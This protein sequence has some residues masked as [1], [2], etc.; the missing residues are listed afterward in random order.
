MGLSTDPAK[1]RRQLEGLA[2]GAE[3]RS[4]TLRARLAELDS[5]P[6]PSEAPPAPASEAPEPGLSEA[7]ATGPKIVPGRFGEVLS[8]APA[9]VETEPALTV[10]TTPEPELEP[11]L[12]EPPA[13]PSGVVR[14]LGDVLG[15]KAE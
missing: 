8:P 7:P 4:A 6:G 11:E 2:I 10:E 1:R 3:R 5:E 9:V 12:D 13:Q 14:F 15:V